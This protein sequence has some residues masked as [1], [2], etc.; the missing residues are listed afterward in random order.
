[1]LRRLFPLLLA[2]LTLLGRPGV[3]EAFENAGHVVLEG[4]GVHAQELEGH[5]AHDPMHLEH[6]CG[7]GVHVCPCHAP[8]IALWNPPPGDVVSA[9]ISTT[10]ALD[11]PRQRSP[12]GF[13]SALFRPPTC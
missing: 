1:M 6:G 13:R 12:L 5:E 4:H 3:S 9:P 10:L 8:T 2:A 11:S 7:G